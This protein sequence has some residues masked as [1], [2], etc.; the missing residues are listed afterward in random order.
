MLLLRVHGL[1]TKPNIGFG[2]VPETTYLKTGFKVQPVRISFRA[3]LK[4]V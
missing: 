3:G 2:L 4:T 1:K